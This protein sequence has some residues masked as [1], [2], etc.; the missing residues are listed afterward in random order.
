MNMRHSQIENATWN[1][2]RISNIMTSD[3][4]PTEGSKIAAV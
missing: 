3:F 2:Q 4:V 1:R